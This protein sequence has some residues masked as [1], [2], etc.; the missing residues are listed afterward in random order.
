ARLEIISSLAT[1][2]ARESSL[3]RRL[4]LIALVALAVASL[5]VWV[6]A[7]VALRPL[8]RLRDATASIAVDEDLERR[9]PTGGPTELRS[10]ASSFNAMLAR[11]GR[12]AADRERALEATRRF[13]ADAGHEL[14][15]PLTSV[16]ATLS[17]L[18]RHSDLETAR[19]E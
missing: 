5:L 3:H 19:R 1:L 11:L 15:T 17:A 12:S 4:A 7:S 2:R 18:G 9:V 16:Q 8:E 13:A 6:V 10:L 14:R